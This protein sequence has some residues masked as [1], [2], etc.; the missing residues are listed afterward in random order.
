M[1]ILGTGQDLTV[2]ATP[3]KTCVAVI[4]AFLFFFRTAELWKKYL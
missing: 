2:A 3:E 1:P 4:P